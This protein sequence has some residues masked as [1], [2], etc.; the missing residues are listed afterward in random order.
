MMR[1]ALALLPV[2]CFLATLNSAH[3]AWLEVNLTSPDP[4]FAASV[5]QNRTFLVNASVY[6][7][8]PLIIGCGDVNGTVMYNASSELPDTQVNETQGLPFFVPSPAMIR[9]PSSPL[10]ADEFCNV[11]WAVNASGL[12]GTGWKVGVLFNSTDPLVLNN[13][14]GN[15]TVSI[16][17]CSVGYTMHWASINFG[18]VNPNTENVSAPG[19]A[20]NQYNITVD[21]NSCPTDFY[22]NSTDLRNVTY[23]TNVSSSNISWSNVSSDIDA[24]FFRMSAAPRPFQRDLTEGLNVTT[25]YW[26]SMPPVF[27]GIYNATIF[28]MGVVKNEA[29]P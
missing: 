6:C 5:V 28:V 25:W 27:S 21:P 4:A 2:I 13:A 16:T 9:C 19:N 10:D 17:P 22:I 29:P 14:T 18:A 23:S 11:T 7:R 24:G 12:Q 8:D 26:L 1:G 20:G 15:A 3:A